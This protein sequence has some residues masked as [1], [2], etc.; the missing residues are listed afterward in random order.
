MSNTREFS[1]DFSVMGTGGGCS[2][3][4]KTIGKWQIVMTDGEAFI[5]REDTAV[6]VGLYFG[7]FFSDDSVVEVLL[8]KTVSDQKVADL[9]ESWE[10][11]I[12]KCETVEE[13]KCF[14]GVNRQI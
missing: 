3:L 13:V 6:S 2:A 4:V 14:L 1:G 11:A 7:D 10:Y 8:D 9:I 12:S 5:P